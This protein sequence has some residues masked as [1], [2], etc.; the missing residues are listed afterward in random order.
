MKKKTLSHAQ[1]ETMQKTKKK[2]QAD[3]P[4]LVFPSGTQHKTHGIPKL[5]ST[6]SRAI[7]GAKNDEQHADIGAKVRHVVIDAV[8]RAKDTGSQC[9]QSIK[10]VIAALC[11]QVARRTRK[12][13]VAS[14]HSRERTA[15][16]VK[17]PTVPLEIA[18]RRGLH[19]GIFI[20]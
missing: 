18:K 7:H 20:G 9:L 6:L 4:F 17:G 10:D 11:M 12:K 1:G 3:R 15:I 2:K 5:P 19:R 13:C 14:V 8:A 16:L